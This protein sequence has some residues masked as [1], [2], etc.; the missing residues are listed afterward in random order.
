MDV[1]LVR[2]TSGEEL[3]G[4]V[5]VVTNPEQVFIENPFIIVPTGDGKISS[6]QYMPYANVANGL[7]IPREHVMWVVTP[8][9]ELVDG[10]KSMTSQILTPNSEIIIQENYV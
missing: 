3:L 7:G 8:A 6:V 1:M 10:W 5:D 2:L 4:N 9:N